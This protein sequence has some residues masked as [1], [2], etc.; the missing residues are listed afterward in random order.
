[1]KAHNNELVEELR[2]ARDAHPA[3]V[4]PAGQFTFALPTSG[5]IGRRIIKGLASSLGERLSVDERAALADALLMLPDETAPT[6]PRT[7][8]IEVGPDTRH[9]LD[10]PYTVLPSIIK[11]LVS[12][13]VKRGT[14]KV[15]LLVKPA[16]LAWKQDAEQNYFAQA[17]GVSFRL[18]RDNKLWQPQRQHPVTMAWVPLGQAERLDRAKTIA[19]FELQRQRDLEPGETVH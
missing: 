19:E 17:A 14:K 13:K 3:D 10:V 6:K 12:P 5:K 15:E 4:P 1:V 9:S 16:T 2:S 18:V 11:P 7:V 8:K